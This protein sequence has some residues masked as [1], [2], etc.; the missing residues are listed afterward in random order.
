MGG[1]RR[2]PSSIREISLPSLE[3]ATGPVE[4]GGSLEIREGDQSPVGEI[5]LTHKL[6]GSSRRPRVAVS[7][8]DSARGR[9]R[10]AK[11]ER[12]SV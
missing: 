3:S 6:S 8:G 12:A 10:E 7:T 4:G 2:W 11:S 1:R 5:N 9:K